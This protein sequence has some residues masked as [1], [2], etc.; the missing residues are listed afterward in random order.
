VATPVTATATATP[1]T[2]IAL[3]AR[4]RLGDGSTLTIAF[5]PGSHDAV[6]D[7]LPVG[8]VV[9]ETPPRA[10]DRSLTGDCRRA[11]AS[12][13]AMARSTTTR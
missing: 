8:K 1:T 12:H 13:G 9:F 11:A 2:P 4:W 3:A 6:L 10:R 5:N 7:T